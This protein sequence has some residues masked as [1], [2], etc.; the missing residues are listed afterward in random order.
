MFQTVPK[1]AFVKFG[2]GRRSL[3]PE[4]AFSELMRL[5]LERITGYAEARSS[6]QCRSEE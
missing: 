2:S 6:C 5:S 3:C 1:F 4:K